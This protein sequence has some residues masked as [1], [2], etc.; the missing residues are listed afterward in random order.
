M[1]ACPFFIGYAT[2]TQCRRPSCGRSWHD[3]FAFDETEDATP[4][5]PSPPSKKRF[6]ASRT[7]KDTSL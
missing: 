1:P 6:S 4:A 7:R 5:L 3:H 2:D